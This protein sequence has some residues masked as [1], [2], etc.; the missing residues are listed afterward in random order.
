MGLKDKLVK[1]L[2]NVSQRLNNILY[3]RD[4]LTDEVLENQIKINEYR[5]K[6][7]ITDENEIV[8][9]EGFVQ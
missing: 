4:G 8:N 7:D 3:E 1:K 9:D 6:Y 5:N 2:L